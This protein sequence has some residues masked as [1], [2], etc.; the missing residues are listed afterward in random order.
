M[1]H[2]KTSEGSYVSANGATY[3]AICDKSYSQQLAFAYLLAAKQEL[4]E[5]LKKIWN[6]DDIQPRFATEKFPELKDLRNPSLSHL[7]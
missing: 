6:T 2:V 5:K 1:K 4:T 3:V 7:G